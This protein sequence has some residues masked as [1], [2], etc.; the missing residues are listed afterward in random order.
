MKLTQ[1]QLIS[2][3]AIGTLIIAGTLVGAAW[4]YKGNNGP[5]SP[6]TNIH[7]NSNQAINTNTSSN[8]NSEVNSV[9][10]VNTS[11]NTNTVKVSGDKYGIFFQTN[12]D[13][14]NNLSYNVE[15]REDGFIESGAYNGY[16]R[17]IAGVNLDM[18]MEGYYVT[19]A[20]KDYQTFVVNSDQKKKYESSGNNLNKSIVTSVSEIPLN[21]PE[22]ISADNFILVRQSPDFSANVIPELEIQSTIGGLSFYNNPSPDWLGKVSKSYILS[23][24]D[25][26][27]VDENDIVYE[28]NFLPSE[29]YHRQ[30]PI[31]I[32]KLVTRSFFTTDDLNEGNNLYSQYGQ[33][34][35]GQC[36]QTGIS[37]VLKDVNA[38]DLTQVVS[39]KAGIKLY[40]FFDINHQIYKDQYDQKIIA[41]EKQFSQVNNGAAIPSFEEYLKKNPVLVFKDPFDRWIGLGEWQYQTAGG[42][43]KPVLYFYPETPLKVSVKF[44]NPVH[45]TTQ[46]P[47]YSNGWNI[48]ANPDG[49]LRN[50]KPQ[51]TNC[52]LINDKQVGSEYAKEACEKNIYPY[53]YWAGKSYSEYPEAKQGWIVA[54]DQIKSFIT[55]KLSEIGLNQ[56]EIDDMTAYW[57]PELLAKNSPFYRL[58]FFETQTMN[59]FIPMEITPK[60]DTFIR[61]FLDWNP[62]DSI[63]GISID[64]QNLRHIERKGFTVVEWGGLKM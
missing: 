62:L 47:T 28:Y 14:L 61:I 18:P 54:R 25:I 42:C 43:G 34:L 29:A 21:F 20:T 3:V 57:V 36:G 58:T 35:P 22:T 59:A 15:Y 16:H 55:G 56:K 24:S 30:Y 63:S 17:V 27:V 33:L 32:Y 46:I 45:L 9:V 50:L 51:E 8:I 52:Q 37:Y 48:L 2:I 4:Y 64:P 13:K 23:S 7:L 31:D 39:T 1:K 53:I 49:L 12:I 10:N 5:V 11:S 19:F 40:K 6:N 41:W 26:L 38:S 44:I 60:P